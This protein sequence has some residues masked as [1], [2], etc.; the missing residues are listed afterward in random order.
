MS[1]SVL[2]HCPF[3]GHDTEI[4]DYLAAFAENPYCR[5]CGLSA[6]ES[7]GKMQDDLAALFARQM[8]VTGVPQSTNPNIASVPTP[9]TPAL[10]PSPSQDTTQPIVYSITQ[11]YHHSSHLVAPA[12]GSGQSSIDYDILGRRDVTAENMLLHHNVNASFLFPSQLTMFEQA[13]V[14]QKA[15]LIELWQISPPDNPIPSSSKTLEHVRVPDPQRLGDMQP[16]PNMLNNVGSNMRGAAVERQ[17]GVDSMDQD[18]MEDIDGHNAEPYVVSG[19]ESLAQREYEH[20]AKK[21]AGQ[22]NSALDTYNQAT[23][24]VYKGHDMWH[25][26]AP[27]QPVEHQYGA[28]E[29]R[30]TYFGCGIRR[31]HWLDDH[32]MLS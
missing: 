31:A 10:P 22:T 7:D 17:H 16:V 1:S 2:H 18:G 27:E 25:Q 12:P 15:R 29:Q 4:S 26:L 8:T 32:E 19:Y 20:S 13:G 5:Q 28:F 3:C 30:N 14:E 9:Q 23:D 24:P 11:H 21:A 6:S